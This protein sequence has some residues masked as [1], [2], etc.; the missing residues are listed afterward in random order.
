MG[1]EWWP[2]LIMEDNAD[3]SMSGHRYSPNK[4]SCGV[5]P[6]LILSSPFFKL[7][8]FSHFVNKIINL[9]RGYLAALDENRNYSALA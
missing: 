8:Y 3:F 5:C 6:V 1:G 4:R 9:S 7:M 2:D